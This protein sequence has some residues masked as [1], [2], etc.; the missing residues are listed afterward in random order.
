MSRNRGNEISSYSVEDVERVCFL[1]DGELWVYAD[2]SAKQ[3]YRQVDRCVEHQKRVK[4][5]PTSVSPSGAVE[6]LTAKYILA[7]GSLPDGF[8]MLD[9]NNDIV[10]VNANVH[11]L[12]SYKHESHVFKQDDGK[13]RDKPYMGRIVD[14]NGNRQVKAFKTHEL[15]ESGVKSMMMDEWGDELRGLNIYGSYFNEFEN[16]F[17]KALET[18]TF[19]QRTI[20]YDIVKDM[21]EDAIPSIMEKVKKME[22]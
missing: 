10:E 9:D 7:F 12:F 13:S 16:R 14:M 3:T 19:P 21:M 5:V 15:A 6:V 17:L 4:V 22:R 2:P 8:V 11:Q 18:R 20:D 1:R